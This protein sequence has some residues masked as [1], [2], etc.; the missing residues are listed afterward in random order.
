MNMRHVWLVAL[1]SLAAFGINAADEGSLKG[2]VKLVGDIPEMKPHDV[3]VKDQAGCNCKQIENEELIVDKATKGIKDAIIRIMDVK[4]PDL[5]AGQKV[6]EVDQKGCKFTPHITIV[7]PG[8]EL[9]ALNP[10]KLSHNIHTTPLDLENQQMNVIMIEEKK[11]IKAKYFEKPEIIQLQ[12]DLH[13]WMKG[14]IVVH[15]PR[16]VAVS[17]ADGTFEIKGVPPGKYKVNVFQGNQGAQDGI[18]VEIKA[19]QATDMGEIKFG[20]K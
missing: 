10:D 15:D 12:C 13:P 14:Y 1:C 5:P 16:Y 8:S 9:V 3:P 7:A 11:T 20:K 4:G 19:G 17:A 2:S 18:D 6:P